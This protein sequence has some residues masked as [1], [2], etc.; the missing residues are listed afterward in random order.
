MNGLLSGSIIQKD[1]Q[2]MVNFNYNAK[3]NRNAR[4][5]MFQI[6]SP[7]LN[8]Q[9]LFNHNPKEI[10][11]A[12]NNINSILS[13]NLKSIFDE[14]QN[15]INNDVPLF[16]NV[17]CLIQRNKQSNRFLYNKYLN[18]KS[19][20]YKKKE[21]ISL[22]KKF[23][24]SAVIQSKNQ[25]KSD[26]ILKKSVRN[27]LKNTVSFS[28][29]SLDFSPKDIPNTKRVNKLNSLSPKNKAECRTPNSKRSKQKKDYFDTN[30]RNSSMFN[31]FKFN[32]KK[33]QV[34]YETE[35]LK[36]KNNEYAKLFKEQGNDL[37]VK[38]HYS[39][40]IN[41]FNKVKKQTKKSSFNMGTKFGN[42]NKKNHSSRKGFSYSG[43]KLGP[44]SN[45][46][47][48]S[49]RGSLFLSSHKN[50]MKIPTLRQ[51]N[52]AITKTFIPSRIG[53]VKKQ[54]DEF[55][56]NEVTE[57]INNL[58]HQKED[59]NKLSSRLTK[60]MFNTNSSFN[61]SESKDLISLNSQTE[62]MSIIED[63]K[64]QIKYRK[65]YLS[66]NLYDSLDDEEVADQEEI[67]TF[68]IS[69][70]SLTVYILDFFV[71]IASFIEL[72][73]LPI[74]ISL[75]MSLFSV[76][77]NIISSFIFYIIDLIY[78]IDL[79]TGFFRAYYNFE[80]ILIKKNSYICINYLTGWFLLD[81]IEA[82]PFFT[83]LNKNMKKIIK[84]FISVNE[85]IS[86]RFDFG[87]NNHYFAL[88]TIKVLKIFKTFSYNRLYHEIH[89]FM[90]SIKF[91][92][93]WKGL[94][95]SIIII[96]SALHFCTCFFI[97]LGKNE[98]QGWIIKN[99]L[100][101][102]SFMDI[103]IASLYYQ[104][105]T[106]TTVGYGDISS[107]DG[108]EHFYGIFILI[109]GTCAYSWIL[110][111]ISNYI[112][113][114]NEKFID[115]EEKMKI[116]TEIKLEY[117]NL[118]KTLFDRIK[119]YLNYN[120]SESK[121]NLKFILESLPS[122]LQN[123]LIIEIYKPIIKNFQFFKSFENS[124]FFVK[125]VTSL[126]PILSMKDDILIQEGDI[127]E[128]I[129]FIKTGV[130]T[131]EIII[132]LNDPK[133]SVESHL[134]MTG[135]DC[136]KNISNNKFTQLMNLNTMS[137]DYRSEFGKQI[138]NSKSDNK[139]E[140]KIIDLRKNEHFGDI[141]MILNEKSPL[142][143]KVR[144]K[145]AELFFLQKTEATEISNRYSNIWKRIVN[146][147]LHNM[148]QIKN[149]IRKKIFLFVETNNIEIDQEVKEK[150][151]IDSQFKDNTS[152]IKENV[153][154]K[155]ST[156]YIE[157]II[158]EEES[159][160]NKSQ[161][162]IS[163]KDTKEEIQKIKTKEILENKNSIDNKLKKNKTKEI[164]INVRLKE[165]IG[166]NNEKINSEIKNNIN[167]V[168][169][170]ISMIDKK[171]KKSSK[172]NQI[173]NFNINIY[174]PKVQFPLTQLNI[175]NHNSSRINLIEKEK[176]KEKEENDES[177]II[178]DVNSEIS[179]N[180]DFTKEIQENNIEMNNLD[181]NNNLIYHNKKL[182]ENKDN[183]ITSSIDDNNTNII[184]LLG[185]KNVEKIA[186]NNK[187]EKIEIKTNDKTSEISDKI[188][189]KENEE[190]L[191]IDK[192]SINKFSNLDTSQSVSF[193][194]NSIYENINQ[195]S[196]F[197]FQKNSD[198]REKTKKFI[199]EEINS[200]KNPNPVDLANNIKKTNDKLLSIKY[201][202]KSNQKNLLVRKKSENLDRSKD[203][204]K[205]YIISRNK[206]SLKI[207]KDKALS[208]KSSAGLTR[209]VANC[210]RLLDM[211]RLEDRFQL[212]STYQFENS[213]LSSQ[214][215]L[216]KEKNDEKKERESK[217]SFSLIN[218]VKT[219]SIKK[220]IKK[221]ESNE[222]NEKTF[223]NKVNS[224]K[225]MK[226]RRVN[227]IEEKTKND[228]KDSNFNFD[229]IISKN[230]EKNQKNLN[231][232]E[233]YFEG[234]FND[235][236]FNKKQGN[237]FK[238]EKTIKKKITTDK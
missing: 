192:I 110:T 85:D 141:L 10:F 3:K 205:D 104:M 24:N 56:N 229:K 136:F 191:K 197:N 235:I 116:L 162:M 173:N 118:G 46:N 236:I 133:K 60:I 1:S 176:E 183:K 38:R 19:K 90:D 143:I 234:F 16:E 150:Y 88:T 78:I 119:R 64:Y 112:K 23:Q 115:F 211:Q 157:T 223:Y 29:K 93:E 54:I 41:P 68:Y 216:P 138:Y 43:F 101:N 172:K 207:T 228:R 123:N 159:V 50:Q 91:F 208:N 137:L 32:L 71:L 206:R 166:T 76:Y 15:E 51:I 144:S 237:N 87:L 127:I 28:E 147:S 171:V 217:K 20:K 99:N 168:N 83:L 199:L 12:N 97:F 155:L 201:N 196:K 9:N 66:K 103:Y 178:G 152:S 49:S 160:L 13:K 189:N 129:I 25:I 114:N 226:K 17:N 69:T 77:D 148:K 156:K 209:Q 204:N 84:N 203:S 35:F 198:L 39:G 225:T 163:D 111:Y 113:K 5:S 139:K 27:S 230:I 21:S 40:N 121:Y 180:K 224:K 45:L 98:S 100:Q 215:S 109:V 6:F 231:N 2:N 222:E 79:V 164:S 42:F 194:I 122:S 212:R 7:K 75:Y 128:D 30:K 82:I 186:D 134:E 73:Y 170:M 193:S 117:P 81:L 65:L 218:I 8:S 154:K 70:N 53:E 22:K 108:F 130:L 167:G 202:I 47:V 131:L 61:N 227:T 37:P 195:I 86:N 26:T 142:A 62:N 105:T 149:L 140:I 72:Y 232:P 177:Y 126:K 52:S 11:N 55:N 59:K 219:P 238:T 151:L 132:D 95:S 179:L 135:M 106:L 153:K 4:K 18:N 175:E 146:R 214:I 181:E 92:Y 124:D 210:S 158:E 96:F 169:N 125:I 36:K 14:N 174:T 221:Q 220:K 48:K 120:K 200:E 94:Y 63:D 34:N 102:N 165:E 57:I 33:P 145:K 182:K 184:K 233:E 187:K 58:P 80:E 67:Y 185:K 44:K 31:N 161:T 188:K 89:K 74:Y 213:K 190:N 107:T